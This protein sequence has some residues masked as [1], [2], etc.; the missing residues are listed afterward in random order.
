MSSAQTPLPADRKD[1]TRRMPVLDPAQLDALV[2]RALAEDVGDG[3]AT[4]AV[5]ID[6]DA[7]ARALIRQKAPGVIYGLEMAE[8][9]F[10]AVDP[11]LVLTRRVEEG[12]WRESGPVL[13]I[14]GNAR[15]LLT[16]ERTAL[17]FLGRLS[18]VATLTARCVSALEGTGARVL[19]TRKTT[20]GLRMLEKAAVWAGGGVNHRIGLYDE[21]LIKENHVAAAGGVGEAV[22]RARAER[23]DLPIE[24]EVENLDELEEAL[25]AGARRVLLD[26]MDLST[27]QTAVERTAGRA[28]LEAS[29]GVTLD[30]LREIG[31]TG[32]DFISVGAL[33]HSAPAL[34]LSLLLESP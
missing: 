7:Q 17:N 12:V 32:V 28:S 34:D 9:A 20:P 18:G 3:D 24:V 27:L 15:A 29:G 33:T 6:A 22:R 21:I 1:R 2:A 14:A 25:A 10:R 11:T 4:A 26:N 31:A 8:R 5:T 23:P 19:D 13:E 30:R 16:G